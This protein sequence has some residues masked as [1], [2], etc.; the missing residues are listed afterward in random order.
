MKV[1]TCFLSSCLYRPSPCKGYISVPYKFS[2]IYATYIQNF[3][4]YIRTYKTCICYRF[5]DDVLPS[6]FPPFIH[7]TSTSFPIGV[8]LHFSFGSVFIGPTLSSFSSYFPGN[9]Q[10]RI[11]S[12][13]FK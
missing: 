12:I 7:P 2:D 10:I 9:G 6:H 3:I 4:I 13:K 1:S 11:Y 5:Q 8:L